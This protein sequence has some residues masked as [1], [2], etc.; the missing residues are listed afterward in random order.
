MGVHQ[1]Y[2]KHL[3]SL[4]CDNDFKLAWKQHILTLIANK[5]HLPSKVTKI[6][7]KISEMG[8][9]GQPMNS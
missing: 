4:T 8:A 2:V 1:I 3:S 5:S 6:K 9:S 7:L